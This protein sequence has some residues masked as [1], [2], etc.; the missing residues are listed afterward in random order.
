MVTRARTQS[1]SEAAQGRSESSDSA[2]NG[3]DLIV[4]GSTFARYEIVRCIGVGGMGSVFEAT[5][6]LLRKRVA[7]K[8]L[9]S[10]LGRAEASRVRF[11]REAE[12]V[13][14]I[15]HPNVVDI[16]D[17]GVEKNVPFLVMEYLE[18]EDLAS[19]L[20][21]EGRL[22]VQRAIDL[23]LPALAGL[24]TVHRLGIV[25]RDVKPE[26]V[27]LAVNPYGEV[28]PKLVD[29][30]VSKDIE[31]HSGK[32]LPVQHTVA[33]TPHY[34]SPEQSRGSTVLDAR[35]DQYA[36]GVLLYQSLTGVKPYDS[37]SLL[38][39]IHQIDAGECAP[40]RMHVPELPEELEAIV[41]RAMARRIEDRFPTTEAFGLAL[42][43]YASE[44]VRVA[45]A[46]EFSGERLP[47][48]NSSA[49]EHSERLARLSAPTVASDA[50]ALS[51]V[52]VT[53]SE[54]PKRSVS[55]VRA[56]DT[57]SLAPASDRDDDAVPAR[58]KRAFLYAA[59]ITALFMTLGVYWLTREAPVDRV[60]PQ[61]PVV[62]L[63]ARKNEAPAT[64]APIPNDPAAPTGQVPSVAAKPVESQPDAS[65]A[66]EGKARPRGKARGDST[67]APPSDIQ[68]SR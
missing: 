37:D 13:A 2:D 9:H 14:R 66:K 61:P 1:E 32:T 29:F 30:G 42:C 33:G 27:F 22:D 65:I 11:L 47:M 56:R 39:L 63:P 67:P 8:V 36:M 48:S 21:R 19:V 12:T 55:G 40:L 59:V 26:N 16:S 68:L 54:T 57:A 28:V 10:S 53:V 35:T 50:A 60:A 7:L 41:L 43:P 15:R 51:N 4:A 3:F 62:E 44:A 5:H 6:A 20:E 38:E 17:V 58:A 64:A 23:V 25:H 49:R 31:A 24:C 52:V 46:R 34:M 18:G 45:C